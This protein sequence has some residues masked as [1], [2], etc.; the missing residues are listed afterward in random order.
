MT[1]GFIQVVTSGFEQSHRVKTN[2][3]DIHD[4]PNE[5]PNCLPIMIRDLD[6]YQV[7][8][9]KLRQLVRDAKSPMP[10]APSIDLADQLARLGEL[11]S[12]GV[13]NDEEFEQ[14]KRKLLV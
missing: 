2:A 14:A 3:K 1:R 7:G 8:L 11:K 10:A 6:Q 12:S 4:R 5:V 9:D 13:L